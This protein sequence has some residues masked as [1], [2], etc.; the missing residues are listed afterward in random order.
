MMIAGT[1]TVPKK[2]TQIA[3]ELWTPSIKRKIQNSVE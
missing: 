3:I 2:K 1:V